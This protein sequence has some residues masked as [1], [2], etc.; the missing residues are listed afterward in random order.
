MH[1]ENVVF[2]KYMGQYRKAMGRAM[3]PC[4]CSVAHSKAVC[5][6]EKHLQA[7]AFA[8]NRYPEQAPAGN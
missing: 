1:W 3:T 2:P 6:P 4:V 5:T 8:A 7:L